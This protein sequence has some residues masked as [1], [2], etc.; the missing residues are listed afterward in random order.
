MVNT[1]TSLGLESVKIQDD[2]TNGE[3][4]YERHKTAEVKTREKLV[5][6]DFSSILENQTPRK[7][8][9]YFLFLVNKSYYSGGKTD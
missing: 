8:S 7:R 2:H 4:R 5:K 6:G 9:I 1:L 3:S